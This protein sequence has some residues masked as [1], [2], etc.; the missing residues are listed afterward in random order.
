MDL[1]KIGKMILECRLE[2]G[3]TQAELAEKV[4]VSDKT[5]SKW[6]KG[7]SLPK[8]SVF[9]NLADALGISVSELASCER[10]EPELTKNESES[11]K[12][13][14]ILWLILAGIL[15]TIL[16]LITILILM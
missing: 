1:E 6:E 9:V 3:M 4:G 7:N 11:K 16:T 8:V 5:I 13:L 2:K 14:S 10:K 12:K 15:I